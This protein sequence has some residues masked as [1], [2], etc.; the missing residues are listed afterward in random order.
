MTDVPFEDLAERLS[1]ESLELFEEMA[2]AHLESTGDRMFI[3]ADTF[4]SATVEY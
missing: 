2:A 3:R 1:P 4:V